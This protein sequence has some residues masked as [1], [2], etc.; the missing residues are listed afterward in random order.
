MKEIMKR[1]LQ[2]GLK[3]TYSLGKVI[4]PITF[5]VT[6]L[7]FTPLLPWLMNMLS[8]VMGLLG[9]PGEAT[10]PLVLGNML[11]LYAGIGGMLTL[12]LTV[13][14]AF[15]IAVMLSFS[16]NL[17]VESS[18]AAK[19]GIRF[20]VILAVRLGLAIV[21]AVSINLLWNGGNEKADYALASAQK[22]LT[23]PSYLEMVLLASE[24]AVYGVLQLA[25]VV[26]P[27]MVVIQIAKE[28]KLLE[29]FSEKMKP[30]T[31][32]LTVKENT[33][34]TLIAGLVLGLAYGAGV[35]IASVK[36]E[37]ISKRDLTLVFI[38]LVAC[39]AVVEDTFIFL[40]LGI[41]ILPLFLI[42][43]VVA[44]ILTLLIA[45]LWS[46]KKDIKIGGEE[47]NEKI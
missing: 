30:M 40:P 23:D 37:N 8:P 9:L 14:E 27:I 7:Q 13:K 3:T 4:L 41:P 26:I 28:K 44:F 1:G 39:H 2:V 25:I 11:N 20:G 36:E 16:H 46:S 35:M 43:I 38:F 34:L 29:K 42:R 10:I 45:K 19:V 32:L 22:E 12:D 6:I 33:S 21:S 18:V 15:I 24:K 17:I 47:K 31:G 5:F